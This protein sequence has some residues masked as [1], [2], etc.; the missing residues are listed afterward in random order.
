[1]LLARPQGPPLR[2]LPRLHRRHLH[3]MI[4]VTPHRHHRHLHPHH[5]LLL[6]TTTSPVYARITSILAVAKCGSNIAVS[7][8]ATI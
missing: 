1:M 3:Q 2:L 7:Y 8:V 4:G 6:M 5:H